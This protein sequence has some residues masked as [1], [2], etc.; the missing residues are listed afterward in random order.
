[1]NEKLLKLASESLLFDSDKFLSP[2][3]KCPYCGKEHKISEAKI[4]LLITSKH[5][6]T[7]ISGRFVTR[8]YKDTYYKIRCCEKCLK[9]KNRIKISFYALIFIASTIFYSVSHSELLSESVGSFL[10]FMLLMYLL[11]FLGIGC[12]NWLLNKTVYDIDIE[13]ARKNNAIEPHS[14]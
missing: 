11:V 2:T 10:G 14:F 1:M 3:F 8:T 13:E 7:K 9:S 4:D 12:L 5:I 6:D